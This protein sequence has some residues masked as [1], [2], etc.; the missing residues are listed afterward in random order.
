MIR[1][2]NYS[3]GLMEES[4]SIKDGQLM[5]QLVSFSFGMNSPINYKYIMLGSVLHY[6]RSP[7]G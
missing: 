3:F 5:H 2:H 6:L 7:K 4:T 1:N